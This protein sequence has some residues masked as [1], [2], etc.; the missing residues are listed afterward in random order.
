MTT[1]T[2]ILLAHG[3]RHPAAADEV[4]ALTTRVGTAV[5][6]NVRQAFLEINRPS[7]AETIDRAIDEGAKSVDVLPLFV[8]T[9]HHVARDLPQLVAA[10]R[11]QHP[12][13]EI[14]LLRHVGAHPAYAA[15]VEIIARE[16][17]H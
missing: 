1:K 13:V 17:G 3:S 2:L 16:A 6:C 11:E 8:N 10:A 7:L 4:A 14:R 5:N 15:I 9:G 12:D